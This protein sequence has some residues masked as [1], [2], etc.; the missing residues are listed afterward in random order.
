MKKQNKSLANF[1]F[2]QHRIFFSRDRKSLGVR[3]PQRSPRK[4]AL[5]THNTASNGKNIFH[6]YS[7]SQ[8]LNEDIILVNRRTT[9]EFS[10]KTNKI[11]PTYSNSGPSNSS[12]KALSYVSRLVLGST[13]PPIK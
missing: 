7:S 5:I 9:R 6:Q 3:V 8:Y 11:H 4:R 13:Q 2:P 10:W 12:G 1:Q